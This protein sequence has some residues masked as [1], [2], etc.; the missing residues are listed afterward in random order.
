MTKVFAITEEQLESLV[1]DAQDE[2]AA[3]II[4]EAVRKTNMGYGEEPT[5]PRNPTHDGNALKGL[6]RIRKW[7]GWECCF[8]DYHRHYELMQNAQRD[9]DIAIEAYDPT[10]KADAMYVDRT[11]W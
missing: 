6:K 1:A 7:F 4:A 10:L 8:D 2:F 5:L 9:I 11:E 3:T